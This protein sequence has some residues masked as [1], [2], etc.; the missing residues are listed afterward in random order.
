MGYQFYVYSQTHN[1]RKHIANNHKTKVTAPLILLY[2]A[3][4][5][6]KID[7]PFSLLICVFYLHYVNMLQIIMEV[8]T[9]AT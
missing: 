5:K 2:L 8:R 4:N 9:H 1:L 3:L 7:I 6:H